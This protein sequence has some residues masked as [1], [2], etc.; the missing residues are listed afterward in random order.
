MLQSY[1]DVES[2]ALC[3]FLFPSPPRSVFFP[4]LPVVRFVELASA[5]GVPETR[6]AALHKG[7]AGPDDTDQPLR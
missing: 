3:F 5:S 4:P 1:D 2:R 7:H 6:A